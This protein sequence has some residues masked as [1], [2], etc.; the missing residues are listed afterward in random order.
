MLLLTPGQDLGSGWD[1]ICPGLLSRWEQMPTPALERFTLSWVNPLSD[2]KP[3]AQEPSVGMEGLGERSEYQHLRDHRWGQ[4][5]IKP[6]QADPV[7]YSLE[8]KPA[9]FPVSCRGE[10]WLVCSEP[11]PEG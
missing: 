7:R 9:P 1:N 3:R 6:F 2:E 5:A 10:G 8:T 4:N 11:G